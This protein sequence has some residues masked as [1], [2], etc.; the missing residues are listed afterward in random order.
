LIRPGKN[1]FSARSASALAVKVSTVSELHH[2]VEDI[3]TVFLE[4]LLAR[5]DELNG[6]QL[7]SVSGR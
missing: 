6:N 4:M 5:S 1:G 3:H 2:R 7:E